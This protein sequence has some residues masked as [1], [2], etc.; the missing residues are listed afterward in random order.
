MSYLGDQK[1]YNDT[2]KKEN[3]LIIHGR[4]VSDQTKGQTEGGRIECKENC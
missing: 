1:L 3:P 2:S 4:L